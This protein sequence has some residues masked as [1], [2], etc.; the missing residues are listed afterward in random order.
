MW[1]ILKARNNIVSWHAFLFCFDRS[2]VVF[3]N[4]SVECEKSMFTFSLIFSLL[5]FVSLLKKILFA[6]EM[7]NN[8]HVKQDI[9][10]ASSRE[11]P[12]LLHA[13]NKGADQ[14]ARPRSLISAFAIRS[15]K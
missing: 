13:N 10:W 15:R 1:D 6:D 7:R 4:G 9:I 8:K 14:P 5:T 2:V 3:H 12:I 11:T